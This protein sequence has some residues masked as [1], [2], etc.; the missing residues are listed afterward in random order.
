[1]KRYLLY[2]F[3]FTLFAFTQNLSAQSECTEVDGTCVEESKDTQTG[4]LN[5]GY[6]VNFTTVGNDVTIS[7]EL[8]D[9]FIDPRLLLWNNTNSQFAELLDDITEGQKLTYT[10]KNQVNGSTISFACKFMWEG[11]GEAVTKYFDYEVGS[12]FCESLCGEPTVLGCTDASAFNYDPSATSDDGSCIDVVSGCT[13]NAAFNYNSSANTDDGSCVDKVRGCTDVN[14]FNYDAS[15]NTDDG[16]CEAIVLGCINTLACNYD[17]SANTNNDTCIVPTGCE[18]CSAENTILVN[19]ADGD[20]VCDADEASG[21]TRPNADNYNS[22]AYEDDGSCV[23]NGA[24]PC[25]R[26]DFTP[27]NTGSNMTLILTS[28][29]ITNLEISNRASYMVAL[30]STGLVVGSEVVAGVNQT[31]M[32]IWGNDDTNSD[33]DGAIEG[34]LLSFQL[35]EGGDL[36]D[37]EMVNPVNYSTNNISP[38]LFKSKTLNCSG[39]LGCN[40]PM[41]DNYDASAT[42]DDGSCEYSPCAALVAADFAVEYDLDSARAVLT[43]KIKNTLSEQSFLSPKYQLVLFSSTFELGSAY[44]SGAKIDSNGFQSIYVPIY[45]DLSDYSIADS[46]SGYVSVTGSGAIDKD[47]VTCEVNFANLFLDTKQV[48]CTD[49]LAHNYSEFAK[50]DNGRCIEAFSV[51]I[52]KQDPTCSY[53]YGSAIIH[54]T[55]DSRSIRSDFTSDSLYDWHDP[56]GATHMQEAIVFNNGYATLDGLDAGEY[57]IGIKDSVLVKN[58]TIEVLTLE[59]LTI[60]KPEPIEVEIVRRDSLLYNVNQGDIVFQQWLFRGVPLQQDKF[61]AHYPQNKGLYEVYVENADGCGY[62]SKSVLILT[63]GVDDSGEDLFQLYPNPTESILNIRLANLEDDVTIIIT[64]VLGQQLQH[65]LLNAGASE[66]TYTFDVSEYPSGLY[67]LRVNQGKS[68][69]VKRFVKK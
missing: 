43:C 69:L 23:Y 5:N 9:I 13:D 1:M 38:A 67:F 3:I 37:L 68:Q 58:D 17:A 62:Y 40:D 18:S 60:T 46:L 12:V 66:S 2:T 32:A 25:L 22:S 54:V 45:N 11:G 48:G 41:A 15:A 61:K 27:T 51:T 63:L 52:D 49:P 6:R 56:S 50:I 47:T 33:I 64:D 19:D 7:F 29:L 55:G 24:T 14:A 39:V 57:I 4:T 42:L 8:L 34:E 44:S 30:T 59:T 26:P 35:I 20:G 65:L 10:L 31:S 28:D 36:Y 16:S 53:D 21:C